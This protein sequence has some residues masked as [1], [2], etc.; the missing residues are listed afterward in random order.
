MQQHCFLL[1]DVWQTLAL[2]EIVALS[3]W[4]NKVFEA[5]CLTAK[6]LLDKARP[7]EQLLEEREWRESH[8]QTL[9]LR[10]RLY[11]DCFFLV[12]Q[13]LLASVVDGPYP[14]SESVYPIE[15]CST[16]ADQLLSSRY[17][18]ASPKVTTHDSA[19]GRD[20]TRYQPC[21]GSR[22]AHYSSRMSRKYGR[23]TVFLSRSICPAWARGCCVRKHPFSL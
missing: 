4:R 12:A 19:S 8:L 14:S 9:E 17:R 15:A 7:I 1:P 10:E 2:A 21:P 6:D 16:T 23:R 18:A 13:I 3:E 11:S 5:G 22:I 20:N